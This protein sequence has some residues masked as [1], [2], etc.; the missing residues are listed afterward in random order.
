MVW[1]HG[2]V[3]RRMAPSTG[4]RPRHSA[5]GTPRTRRVLTTRARSTRLT[6]KSTHCTRMRMAS[7][8]G[9]FMK[10]HFDIDIIED[11]HRVRVTNKLLRELSDEISAAISANE[12]I[13]GNAVYCL[14]RSEEHTSE[15]Q[16][17][18]H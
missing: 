16:S 11:H 15:L 3:E 8:K 17:L 10:L 18:R 7:C 6:R 9:G 2:K 14:A 13:E 1:V 12:K 4:T 5:Q